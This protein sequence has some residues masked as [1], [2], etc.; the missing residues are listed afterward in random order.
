MFASLLQAHV[1]QAALPDQNSSSNDRQAGA[2]AFHDA[3]NC[4]QVICLRLG[5]VV[6][7]TALQAK[8]ECVWGHAMFMSNI[9][10]ICIVLVTDNSRSCT[11]P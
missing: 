8:A 1:V 4:H 11:E 2:N 5:E 9:Q 6:R 7:S 10:D 3:F